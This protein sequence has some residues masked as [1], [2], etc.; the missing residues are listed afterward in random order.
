MSRIPIVDC[1]THTNFSDGESTFT[2][3]L[4][5]AAANDCRVLAFTDHLTLPA[6]MDPEGDAMVSEAD[7]PAG[8]RGLGEVLG[9]STEIAPKTGRG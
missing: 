3:V 5:A 6:S 2:E 9:S 7:L 4:T 8:Q 1:H